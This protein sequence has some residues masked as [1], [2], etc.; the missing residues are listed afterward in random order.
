[1]KS[2]YVGYKCS[3]ARQLQDNALNYANNDFTAIVYNFID[4]LSQSKTEMEVLK[5][6]AGD[7]KAFIDH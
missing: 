6:L 4:M 5:E 7:E 2:E 3:G 1:M